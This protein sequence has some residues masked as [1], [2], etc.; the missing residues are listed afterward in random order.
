MTQKTRSFKQ[1]AG[2]YHKY[3]HR[4]GFYKNM[5]FQVMKLSFL[6]VFLVGALIF[7]SIYFIDAEKIFFQFTR[8]V[9]PLYV[10]VLFLFS[11][12]VF[13]SIIPPDLFIL[14]ADTFEQNYLFL[15]IL[16]IISWMGGIMSYYIG[17]LIVHIPA[18]RR[19]IEKRF[20]HFMRSISKWGTFFI[21][22]AALLPVPW[23]P[24]LIAT[25]M[26]GYPSR[27]MFIVTAARL[28][29]FYIYGI[30]IFSSFFLS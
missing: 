20:A 10:F 27:R 6:I 15:T 22:V 16:A 23:A 30:I 28:L 7:I 1:T 2:L 14:W 4:T 24:A 3:L 21:F 25:G 18:V 17:R 12:S 26:L 9:H 19:W 5:M 13:L 8:K 11:E 29:R